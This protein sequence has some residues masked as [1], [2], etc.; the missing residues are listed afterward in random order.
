MAY[1]IHDGT[2][3]VGPLTLDELK[4]KGIS[5]TTLVWKD[6][7]S[8]W[9]HASSLDEL[10][11]ILQTAPPVFKGQR[12]PISPVKQSVSTTEKIGFQLGKFLGWTGV[13]V[14]IF[15]VAMF[16]ANKPA[17]H[18]SPF[19][20]PLPAVDPEH[21]NP[22]QYLVANGTY[23]PNFW[24][25]KEQISGAVT[26][27]ATHTNYK[28]VHIQVYFYS[29]TKSVIS[30]QEY[31]LYNYFPYGTTTNFSLTVN[32]PAAAATC[33]WTAVGATYY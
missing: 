1:F 23:R 17:T 14:L 30:A 18:F 4:A 27:R 6:G 21:A 20:S 10:K 7:L 26:N 11:S 16:M 25:T 5:N 9:V 22:A 28:D 8:D 2:K 15:L 13:G 12:G 24:L 3:Q 33:G 19:I 32:K 31:V 29:Q